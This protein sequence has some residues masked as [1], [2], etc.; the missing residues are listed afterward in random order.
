MYTPKIANIFDHIQEPQWLLTTVDKASNTN[1]WKTNDAK[2][3]FFAFDR[4]TLQILA[5]K[6][7][8]V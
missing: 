4:F 5:N 2:F 3:F 1:S 7:E 6:S 8:G